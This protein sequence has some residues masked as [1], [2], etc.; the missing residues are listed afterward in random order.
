MTDMDET[1]PRT[2]VEPVEEDG[3]MVLNM[4]P[5]HP[6]TH[7]VI[8]L[9]LRMDG[10]V[11]REAVPDI[12]YLHRG[13]EKVAEKA[14]WAG[15]MPYT[16]RVDYLGAMFVNHA[17]ARVV[18]RLL[19]IEVPPRAEYLR[20]LADELN[21]IASHLICLGSI[22]MDLGAYT[23]FLH[24][25]REREK[26]NDLFEEWCGA[27]LTYN[28]MRVGGV[29]F[30]LPAGLRPKILDFLDGFEVF[31][32]EFNRLI[33]WNEIF[34]KRC[35]GIGVIPPDLAVGYGL[36]GPN[37][38][39]SG[40]DFDLRRDQPYAAYPDLEFEVPVGKGYAGRVGDTFDRFYVRIL[41]MQ[42]SARIIRQVL[43][44]LPLGPILGKVPKKI[45][46]EKGA[47]AHA[48]IESA[49]GDLFIYA[50]ADG[51]ENPWRLRVRTGSFNALSILGALAPGMMVADLVAFFA[52]LD[53]IAPE[54]DR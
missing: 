10:E 11:I 3:E 18:E 52:S 35:A 30:D 33:T 34:V 1:L 45:K 26:I 42:Q 54:T 17:Y 40:V 5:H 39:A 28:Y 38:R 37:L 6:S 49:R 15:F 8:R 24:G 12:G 7:G 31:I 23:P 20:V 19:G 4:G 46:P 51:T 25:I 48:R 13:I 44:R 2:M 21:R 36:V 29:S 9:I 14:G 43:R 32:D 53:V 16:D 22:T 47:E 41:E 50:M 27:R